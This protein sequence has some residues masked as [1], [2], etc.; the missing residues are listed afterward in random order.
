MIKVAQAATAVDAEGVVW[1][2]DL[3]HFVVQGAIVSREAL[4]RCP[5]VVV[6]SR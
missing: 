6:R 3:E 4:A 2:K 5:S 1:S